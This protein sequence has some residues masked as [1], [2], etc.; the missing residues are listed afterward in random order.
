MHD[1]REHVA[2]K[3][4]E[5][6]QHGPY[7]VVVTDC[8]LGACDVEAAELRGVAEVQVAGCTTEE[9]V[10][11]AA[12]NA[13]GLLVQYAPLTERVI[14]SLPACQV[15]SRYGVGID[16]VDVAAATRH[17][18]RVCNVPNYCQHEVSDHACAMILALAR[19]LAPLERLVRKGSWDVRLARP[20]PRLEERRLG[21][22]GFGKIARLVARKM[23]GF[24]MP[25]SAYDPYV[26]EEAFRA[27]GVTKLGFDSLLEQSD[28]ISLHLPLTPQSMH[29]L[30]A[31][32]L[33]RIK[34]DALLVNT[35]RGQ[36]IDENALVAAL[37]DGR[38]G[39]VALDVVEHEPL[40]P[41]S[42]LLGFENV[43]ITPHAA[44]YSE[45]SIEEL[46][47]QTA[48]AVARVLLREPWREGDGY[49]V[50]NE[51]DI[52]DCEEI[53]QRLET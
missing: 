39:G 41:D 12:G 31:G 28:I 44:Y 23:R 5:R 1:D 21:L 9:Q 3:M 13:D 53:R 43:I 50:V 17:G 20:I 45:A 51:K 10:I 7:T 24:E 16:S 33:A 34:M 47:R 29:I 15:I 14:A 27:E 48:R 52:R 40:R 35:S 42:P 6:K 46:K 25:I 32:E 26:A 36:L 11:E 2:V 38:L 8:D 19:K 30:S 22:L 18:V 37:R 4:S 49:A